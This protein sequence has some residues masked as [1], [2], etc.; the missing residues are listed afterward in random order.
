[1]SSE[2]KPWYKIPMPKGRV[3]QLDTDLD[4]L[5]EGLDDIGVGPRFLGEIRKG[6]W[7]AEFGGPKNKYKSFFPFVEVMSDPDD[8]VDGRV[9][10]IGP[11]LN[12]LP[13]ETSVPFIGHA[14]IWGREVTEFH[15]EFVTRGFVL[16]WLQTENCGGMGVAD[17]IWM[18][19]G[20]K[21]TPKFSFK[22]LAQIM[23]AATISFC[24]IVEKIELKL[25]IGTPEIGGREF[26][27]KIMAEE[28]KPKWEALQ[29]AHAA[30]GDEDVDTFFGCT[31]CKMIAPNH[32]CI[33]TPAVIPYCGV[34]SYYTCK[35]VFDVDPHGYIFQFPKGETID[36]LAGRYSGV[37]DA[38][39]ERSDHRHA[40][41]H[42]HSS[43]K[44][45]TTN[46]GCFEAVAFYIPQV[47][48]I[49]ISIRRYMGQ[50]PL[51]LPFSKIAG[52]MS[53]GVQN[54]GFKG[55]SVHSMRSPAFLQGD[56]GW[57]RIVWVPKD[58][59]EELADV[60]PEE[61]YA[62]IATE[63]DALDAKTLGTFLTEKK[64]PVTSKY[65]K[66]GKPVPVRVPLPGH[67]WADE[68]PPEDRRKKGVTAL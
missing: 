66:E 48:G 3:Y 39:W 36:A 19:I 60:I 23:R 49:G 50:T 27:E 31:L 4:K 56:G 6:E 47:D 65:W 57:N 37:D 38:I 43:L 40:I 14:R 55:T 67:D 2:M 21:I 20:K 1:M 11:E 12:E 34:L 62:S 30:I 5:Y 46:C 29:A 10:L 68:L 7:Y 18:R 52:L 33:I 45:S 59:K 24:P 61:V 63:D 25:I 41:F 28:I 44:Y 64:H 51:G 8:V 17:T 9:E 54:H 53:G 13:P 22:K 58:L 42:L 35:A 26:I 32:A 15:T 16:G